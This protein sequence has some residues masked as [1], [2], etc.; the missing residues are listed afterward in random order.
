MESAVL[1]VLEFDR[2]L[3]CYPKADQF[4]TQGEHV[5]LARLDAAVCQ[6]W[7]RT[8]WKCPRRGD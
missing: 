4:S 3:K 8:A 5:G 6:S 1:Q 7:T 2:N